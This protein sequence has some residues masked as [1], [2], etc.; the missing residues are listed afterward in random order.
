[1][2]LIG[3][4]VGFVLVLLLGFTHHSGIWITQRVM[5]SVRVAR[6]GSIAVLFAG[7]LTLHVLEILAFAVVYAVLTSIDGFGRVADF[8]EPSF[9]DHVYYSGIVFT[10]L[11][12]TDLDATGP[13]R[14]ITMLQALGG[15]MVLTWS[16]TVIYRAFGR[17]IEA[18]TEAPQDG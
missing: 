1:M 4:I 8:L 2:Q 9:A 14:M 18:R 10:T 6:N 7:L 13:I 16:A 12:Y 5:P 15:F 3:F 11:G 17:E